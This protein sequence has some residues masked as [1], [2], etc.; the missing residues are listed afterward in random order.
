MTILQVASELTKLKKISAMVTEAKVRKDVQASKADVESGIK[1]LSKHLDCNRYHEAVAITLSLLLWNADGAIAR[2]RRAG[3]LRPSRYKFRSKGLEKV[4]DSAF[5]LLPQLQC[6]QDRL[7]YLSSVRVL[8]KAA[9]QAHRLRQGL[10]IRLRTHKEIVLKSLLVVVN[11]LFISNWQSDIF[12]DSDQFEHWG[13]EDVAQAFSYVLNLMREEVGFAP[14]CWVHVDDQLG[15]RFDS[16]YNSLLIDAAKLNEFREVESLIDGM[17]YEIVEN[18]QSL[19]VFSTD[20]SFE[21]SVRLGYMQAE[22]QSAIRAQRT[23][24]Y[25]YKPDSGNQTM[26]EFIASAFQAGMNELLI[27]KQHPKERLV[28]MMPMIAEFF[29]PIITDTY[30]IEELPVIIG[31]G[32]DDFLPEG[33]DP[34]KIRVSQNLNIADIIKVQRL[35]SFVSAVFDEKLRG[36]Q[37]A[38]RRRI[39]KIR[40]VIPVIRHDMLLQQLTMILPQHKAEEVVQLLTLEESQDFIDVQYRP[41]IKFGDYY[42]IAPALVARSNLSRNTIVANKMRNELMKETDPMQNAVMNVLIGG[43]FKVKTEFTFNINGKRETDIFC[44]LDGHLF[45]F[46]CKNSFHPCSAHELRTSYEHIKK[47]ENQLDIRLN[48]LKTP[49]NQA[50]L[51]LALGWN[52]PITK[53]IHTGIITANR[54]FTGYTKGVHPVRQAHEFINVIQRGAIGRGDMP[55]LIFW[56]GPEFSVTDLVDYLK[57]ESIVRMQMSQLQPFKK[58]IRFGEIYLRLCRYIMKLPEITQKADAIFGSAEDVKPC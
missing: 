33:E 52:V 43:G 47:A 41:F 21:Q 46:E 38:E 7:K 12:A 17:P 54:L 37:D 40:S 44:W 19:D 55:P 23:A 57:G 26:N 27:T 15:G 48:W 14:N 2:L 11:E 6:R 20:E 1:A 24:Q 25:F 13:A 50:K 51:L 9:P 39:L 58:N 56:K 34:R 22:I 32:I 42:I 31:A 28:F 3:V 36:I 29:A 16:F 30:F 53:N 35:F 8:L 45:V 10:V 5:E 49:E 4:L 18:G